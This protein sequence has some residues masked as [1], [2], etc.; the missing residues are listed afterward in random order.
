MVGNFKKNIF[1]TLSRFYPATLPESAPH[2]EREVLGALQGTLS[3]G[4][5]VFPSVHWTHRS[6][7][8]KFH[9]GEADF[10]LYH[11]NFAL[12]VLEVKGGGIEFESQSG[13]WFTVPSGGQRRRLKESPFLQARS[14]LYAI[15]KMLRRHAGDGGMPR[16][17][18][19]GVIFPAVVDLSGLEDKHPQAPQGIVAGKHHLP[20]LGGWVEKLAA[21]WMR[22]RPDYFTEFGGSQEKIGDPAGAPADT[23]TEYLRNTLCPPVKLPTELCLRQGIA[24]EEKEFIELSEEQCEVLNPMKRNRRMA[25]SGGAGTGKTMLAINKALSFARAGI[26]TL[27]TCYNRVLADSMRAS[28]RRALIASADEWVLKD[29]ILKVQTLTDYV[30]ELLSAHTEI[31]EGGDVTRNHAYWKDLPV[32][33]SKWRA[34]NEVPHEYLI[35][36]MVMDE[37]QDFGED[38]WKAIPLLMY[39]P[40]EDIIWVFFDNNQSIYAEGLGDYPEKLLLGAGVMDLDKN[41]RNTKEIHASFQPYCDGLDQV[42][43]GPKGREPEVVRVPPGE[44]VLE[45]VSS[46]VQ[47]LIEVEKISPESIAVLTPS[48]NSSELFVESLGGCATQSSGSIEMGKVVVETVHSFKGQE[49]PVVVLAEMNLAIE[50]QSDRLRYIAMSRA[51]HH[52]VMVG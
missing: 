19:H 31:V 2:A 25:V 10:V 45:T 41:F 39:Q 12:L 40:D 8:G 52:L 32:R 14:N 6:R 46:V 21:A 16:S 47:K 37:G 28:V 17:W 4:W 49:S 7:K 23:I 43:A 15:V 27:L 22:G 29:E 1:M 44:T 18:G 5:T 11:P 3:A 51:V 26:P 50:N 42:A 38:W 9:D 34:E 35:Q 36:A 33:F 30:D 20:T 48:R 24:N 13:D